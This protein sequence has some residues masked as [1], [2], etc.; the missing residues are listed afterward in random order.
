MK[1]VSVLKN[2][3]ANAKTEIQKQRDPSGSMAEVYRSQV[4]SNLPKSFTI[5]IAIFK[6]LQKHL[7][8]L[9]LTTI[10]LMVMC[11]CNLFRPVLTNWQRTTEISVL[12]RCWMVFVPL[13]RTLLF[14]KSK[15]YIVGSNP[16]LITAHNMAN[17][18]IIPPMPFDAT[19]WL[20]NN[21]A[22]RLSFACKGLWLDMLCCMWVSIERGVMLKPIGG[23]YTVDELEALY[24][25]GTKE[26]IESLIN[27]EL[28]S[29][30]HDGALYNADM[31]KMESIRIKRSEAGKKVV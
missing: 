26:L 23:A 8:K 7:L 3:T 6:E 30:R 9:S 27:A 18:K 16:P 2:F 31:V 24:G 20:S 11:C 17:K 19:A 14:L 5:N 4:E 29:V 22:M 21:A 15:Y 28:L 25:S 10:F 1:L 13:P 12:M